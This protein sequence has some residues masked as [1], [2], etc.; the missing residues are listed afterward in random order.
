V[1]RTG[2]VAS[3][4]DARLPGHNIVSGPILNVPIPTPVRRT[5]S[6]VER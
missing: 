4:V 5:P 6:L 3:L 2:V 1:H